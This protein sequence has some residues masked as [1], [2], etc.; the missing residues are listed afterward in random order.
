M[1]KYNVRFLNTA[2]NLDITITCPENKFI[3]EA[4][5]ENNIQLPYSCRAGSCSTCIGK[6]ISGSIEHIDQTFLEEEQI[7][8]GYV[9]TCVACPTSDVTIKTHEESNLY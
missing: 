8:S 4:A 3:L 5:E 7:K 6:V 1:Q 9:L 2:H